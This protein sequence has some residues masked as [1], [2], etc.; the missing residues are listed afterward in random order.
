MHICLHVSLA[1]SVVSGLAAGTDEA[2][3]GIPTK[4][5]HITSVCWN[6]HLQAVNSADGSLID[7][8]TLTK[9]A[10]WTTSY[11]RQS[12]TMKTFVGG[13]QKPA[14]CTRGCLLQTSTAA[15]CLHKRP[16]KSTLWHALSQ[17]LFGAAGNFTYTWEELYGEADMLLRESSPF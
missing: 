7:Q 9:P 5:T 6:L 10:N 12:T 3:P 8:F 14:H 1:A 17:D 4:C 13:L 16:V 15:L 11:T 2:M